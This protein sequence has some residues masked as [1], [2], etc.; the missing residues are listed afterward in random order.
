LD[1]APIICALKGLPDAIE[2][3][4]FVREKWPMVID[5]TGQA[6]RFLRYQ[7]GSY[8][9]ADSPK[10]VADIPEPREFFIY[11]PLNCER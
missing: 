2:T 1:T 10:V 7:R 5:P 6:G 11:L 8:L 9:I 4:I 3:A